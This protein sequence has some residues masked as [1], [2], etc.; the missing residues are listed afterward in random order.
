M[1]VL[2]VAYACVTRCTFMCVTVTEYLGASVCYQIASAVTGLRVWICGYQILVRGEIGHH[3][4]R[5]GCYQIVLE[6]L[7]LTLSI[8]YAH[9][10]HILARSYVDMRSLQLRINSSLMCT[11]R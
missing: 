5:L 4:Q 11:A 1:R 7:M 8:A 10:E 3:E 6:W 2:L 9:L